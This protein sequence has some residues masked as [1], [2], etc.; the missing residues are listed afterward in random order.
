MRLSSN[1]NFV[2][3]RA[4]R[5]TLGGAASLEDRD[6]S[7]LAYRCSTCGNCRFGTEVPPSIPRARDGGKQAEHIEVGSR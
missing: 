3:I 7:H 4:S 2:P 6:T 5:S 1:L